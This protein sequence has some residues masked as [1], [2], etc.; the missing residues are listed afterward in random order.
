[1]SR[2]LSGTPCAAYLHLLK[3]SGF[4][5]CNSDRKIGETKNILKQMDG[6]LG[7][8]LAEPHAPCI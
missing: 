8:A 1:M 4:L 6:L 5:F 2:G 7:L 3:P